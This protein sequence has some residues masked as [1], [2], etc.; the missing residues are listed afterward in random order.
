MELTIKKRKTQEWYLKAITSA[1]VTIHRYQYAIELIESDINIKHVFNELNLLSRRGCKYCTV[2]YEDSTIKNSLHLCTLCP[3]Y[4]PPKVVGPSWNRAVSPVTTCSNH[5]T[6]QRISHAP[7]VG[8]P[9]PMIQAIK[10]RISYH[11]GLITRMKK[12]LL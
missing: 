1:E 11:K 9:L 6:F 2:F 3:M 5:I 8:D 4:Q 12:K 10:A 7:T